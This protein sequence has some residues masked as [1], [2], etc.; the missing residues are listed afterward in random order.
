M[1]EIFAIDVTNMGLIS[2][3]SFLSFSPHLLKSLKAGSGHSD[4]PPKFPSL[5]PDINP[6]KTWPWEPGVPLSD[7][8]TSSHGAAH[9]SGNSWPACWHQDGFLSGPRDVS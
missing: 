6:Q 4:S 3:I 7:P 2:K 5:S 9:T 1:G 8:S